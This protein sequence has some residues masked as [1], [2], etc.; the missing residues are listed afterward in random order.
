MAS[1]RAR[2]LRSRKNGDK[3]VPKHLKVPRGTMPRPLTA[4]VCWENDQREDGITYGTLKVLTRNYEVWL[5]TI[6]R[7]KNNK[8]SARKGKRIQTL[9]TMH[10]LYPKPAKAAE[11]WRGMMIRKD[12]NA[13]WSMLSDMHLEMLTGK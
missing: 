10:K 11:A 1:R 9:T 6:M 13:H 2:N 4:V 7:D 5:G 8:L 12:E 3:R